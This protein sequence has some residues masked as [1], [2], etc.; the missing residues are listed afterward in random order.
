MREREICRER[1]RERERAKEKK[2]HTESRAF[3][4]GGFRAKFQRVWNFGVLERD[5]FRL[6]VCILQS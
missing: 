4:K 5:P 1:E 6:R 2:S 3:W